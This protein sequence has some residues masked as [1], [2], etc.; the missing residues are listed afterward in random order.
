MHLTNLK[1]KSKESK[2]IHKKGQ[3]KSQRHN[4]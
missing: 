1:K 4:T 3:K 2:V